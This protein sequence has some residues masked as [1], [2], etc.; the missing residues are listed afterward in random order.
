MSRE[1]QRLLN[2]AAY[3]IRKQDELTRRKRGSLSDNNTT[4]SSSITHKSPNSAMLSSATRKKAKKRAIVP[5]V[6]KM[7]VAPLNHSI[8]PL[9]PSKM[10]ETPSLNVDNSWMV[11]PT[12]SKLRRL[13]M[14]VEAAEYMEIKMDANKQRSGDSGPSDRDI[15]RGKRTAAHMTDDEAPIEVKKPFL[16][17]V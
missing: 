16:A 13:A 3:M 15:R 12:S 7:D 17:E 8:S 11:N 10:V 2:E 6:Q 5:T 14:L 9:E 1:L 4:T